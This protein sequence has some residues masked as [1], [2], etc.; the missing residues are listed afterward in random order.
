[1]SKIIARKGQ[2]VAQG[3]VIGLVGSTGLATGPHVC[4]R[5]W[6]NGV[7]VDPL[8]EKLPDATPIDERL[9]PRYMEAIAP[10]K[11]QLDAVPYTNIQTTEQA[12][13]VPDTLKA[14]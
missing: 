10:L 8:K 12:E 14:Q 11:K 4:Y 9:K 13:V 3:E 7:Q 2:H 6:K 5:F 1:M